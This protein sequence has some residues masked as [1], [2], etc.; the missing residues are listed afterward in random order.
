MGAGFVLDTT[1]DEE[2]VSEDLGNGSVFLQHIAALASVFGEGV[3]E[4]QGGAVRIHKRLEMPTVQAPGTQ[5]SLQNQ[6]RAIGSFKMVH[7]VHI[8]SFHERNGRGSGRWIPE[9]FHARRGNV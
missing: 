5:L 9:R 1:L 8:G 4:I 7:R 2:V 6:I 3:E